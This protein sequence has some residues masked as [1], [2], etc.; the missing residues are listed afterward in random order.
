[1]K[2]TK[3]IFATICLIQFIGLQMHGQILDYNYIF[4][5][6]DTWT[7]LSGDQVVFSGAFDDDVSAAVPT[8]PV[9]MGVEPHSSLFISTNGF[10]T[11]STAPQATNYDPLSLGISAPVIAPFATN[12]EGIDATSK[13]SYTIDFQGI[14]VQWKNVR[15]VGYVG[16]SFSFQARIINQVYT[17]FGFGS[18]SFLYGPFQGVAVPSTSVHVG[19]RVGTGDTAGTF[20]TR[21]VDPGAAWLPDTFGTSSTSTC[22]FPSTNTADGFPAEGMKQEWFLF[23]SFQG[24]TNPDAS[25]LC[26]GTGNVAI[27]S[28]YDG[29]TLNINV[30]QDIPNLKI[31]ICTYEP[32]EIN[33][34]GPYVSNV[35]EVLYAGFNNSTNNNACNLGILTSSISG[36][37]PS[38]TQ[39]LTAPPVGYE[40]LH[41]NGSGGWGGAFGGPGIMVGVSGQ[42]DTLY[43]AGGGN[44]PDEVVYYFLTA[45]DDDLLFHHTQY[46]CWLTEVY[47]ISDGGNCCVNPLT[48]VWTIEVPND[49]AT[50]YNGELSLYLTE[51]Q[52]GVGPFTYEWTYNTVP[53]CTD[54]S[55]TVPVT[56]DGEA[57]LTITNANGQNLSDCFDVSVDAPIFIAL[58]V[59]DTVLCMP[60]QFLLT[61]DTDPSTF[62]SQQWTIEGTPYPNQSNVTFTPTQPGVFD[63]ALEVSTAIGC[64]YDTLLTDYLEAYPQPQANYTSEPLIL[65]ADNT[66]VTLLDLSQGSIASWEWTISLPSEELVSMEQNPAFS[67]PLGVGGSYPMQL[68][69]ISADGCSD[70]IIGVLTVNE[71]FNLF[72]PVAF[73][74]NGDGINDVFKIESSGLDPDSFRMEVFNRWGEKVFSSTDPGQAWT[75][76]ADGGD[77]YMPNGIYYYYITTSSVKTGERFYYK[78][79]FTIVR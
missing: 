20:A 57:C 62:T 12:L 26:N 52:N 68:E 50:C 14:C 46:D 55:C 51:N 77:F 48:P 60:A 75:G 21:S 41:G 22:A 39:I 2:L 10:I 17:G 64:A 61:N 27:Y 19:I 30:D 23:P 29:G 71:M 33:I 79:Y 34:T 11:L 69:V 9:T 73:S 24:V 53:V 78:G 28:N 6:T 43:V 7:E 65:E 42:C 58:S 72:I 40:P 59:S 49:T 74:P 3:F 45:F 37:A 18:I 70:E 1:M 5:S 38:I 8:L 63:I 66:D 36:V 31:G 56:V 47:D 4:Q 32:V 76:G 44:T 13:V 54:A 15:R 35:T 67:L 25:P 16:E